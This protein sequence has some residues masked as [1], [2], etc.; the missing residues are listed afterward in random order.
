MRLSTFHD[1]KTSVNKQ[2]PNKFRLRL[3]FACKCRIEVLRIDLFHQRRY[4]LA[5]I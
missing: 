5:E 1:I 3:N 4:Y 2:N